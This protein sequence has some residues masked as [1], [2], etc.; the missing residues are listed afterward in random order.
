MIYLIQFDN[1]IDDNKD[2]TSTSNGINLF[3]FN[4][5]NDFLMVQLSITKDKQNMK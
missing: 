4:R 5:N 2:E 1:N 3:D